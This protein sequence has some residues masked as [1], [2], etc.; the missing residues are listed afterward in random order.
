MV[1]QTEYDFALPKGFVDNE[2]NLHKKGKIRLATAGD[3]ILPLKDP[4]VQNN[5]AY[6][7]TIVFARVIT[8]L[9]DLND[10]NTD[11]IEKLF[12]GDLSYLQELYQRINGNGTLTFNV[13]CPNCGENF[14]KELSCPGD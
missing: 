4:R 11:V 7:T 13:K 14:D 1:L 5:P 3:E 12:V 8:K 2:G 6:L 9:G 10:V